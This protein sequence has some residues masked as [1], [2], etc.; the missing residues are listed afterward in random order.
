[1]CPTEGTMA[2]CKQCGTEI[3]R[4]FRFCPWCGQVQ[5]LKLTEFFFGHAGIEEGSRRALR[6]S[7]Y[8][9]DADDERH[10]RFSVWSEVAAGGAKVEAAVSLDENEADRVARFLITS[11]ELSEAETQ[12]L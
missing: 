10:V 1:M 9:G 2:S 5:R 11:D 3:E 6:I 8:F 4:L 12:T 7:R